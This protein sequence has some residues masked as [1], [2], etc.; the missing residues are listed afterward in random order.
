MG[1]AGIWDDGCDDCY[2]DWGDSQG[3]RD[4]LPQDLDEQFG[5]SDSQAEWEAENEQ[6]EDLTEWIK[7]G[8]EKRG[9][10]SL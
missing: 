5:I 2:S 3:A 9:L 6:E 1:F 4:T 8:A 7:D 10:V